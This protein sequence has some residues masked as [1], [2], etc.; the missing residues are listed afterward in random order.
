VDVGGSGSR[1]FATSM[2]HIVSTAP[3]TRPVRDVSQTFQV[4]ERPHGVRCQIDRSGVAARRTQ[5][6]NTTPRDEAVKDLKTAQDLPW[7]RTTRTAAPRAAA[8]CWTPR[9]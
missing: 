8:T 3:I 9:E 1:P 4:D 2:A 7:T 6:S 5:M